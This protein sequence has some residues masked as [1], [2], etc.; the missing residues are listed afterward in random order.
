[1]SRRAVA[2]LAVVV[3]VVVAAVI[4]RVVSSNGD[5]KT[6]SECAAAGVERPLPSRLPSPG[7]TAAAFLTLRFRTA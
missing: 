1:M 7:C 6:A 3:A 4:A 2:V 5:E